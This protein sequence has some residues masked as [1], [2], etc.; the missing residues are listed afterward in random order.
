MCRG[1]SLGDF[2]TNS[3]GHPG[4]GHNSCFYG[5]KQQYYIA[6]INFHLLFFGGPAS[7]PN[8][9]LPNAGS[10]NSGSPN[11]GS[12]NGGSP[13]QYRHGDLPKR[14]FAKSPVPRTVL[15]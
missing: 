2:F 1:Y 5:S 12:P 15:G 7:S 14:R 9:I 8:V 10:P 11:G 4:H 13:K 6:F 3:S